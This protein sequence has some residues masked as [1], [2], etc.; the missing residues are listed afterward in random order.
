MNENWLRDA[1]QITTKVVFEP[2]VN[3]KSKILYAASPTIDYNNIYEKIARKYG[4]KIP[5]ILVYNPT[6]KLGYFDGIDTSF[7]MSKNRLATKFNAGVYK[8]DFN[9]EYS[10]NSITDS[11]GYVVDPKTGERS[12]VELDFH[13]DDSQENFSRY[14]EI[15]GDIQHG[16]YPRDFE[17]DIWVGEG[18]ERYS[19]SEKMHSNLFIENTS[20]TTISTDYEVHLHLYEGITYNET[21]KKFDGVNSASLTSTYLNREIYA[22]GHESVIKFTVTQE[23]VDATY[24][25]NPI[26]FTYYSI[27]YGPIPIYDKYTIKDNT[28]VHAIIDF[29]DHIKLQHKFT[30]KITRWSKPYSSVK[31]NYVNTDIVF[32]ASNR[33]ILIEYGLTNSCKNNGDLDYGL[34]YN[35]ANI[36]LYSDDRSYGTVYQYNTNTN[37]MVKFGKVLNVTDLLCDIQSNIKCRFYIKTQLDPYYTYIGKYFSSTVNYNTQSDIVNIDC[38]DITQRLQSIQTTGIG[39]NLRNVSVYYLL[40]ELVSKTNGIKFKFNTDDIK[41]LSLI[42]ISHAIFEASTLWQLLEGCCEIGQIYIVA[43]NYDEDYDVDVILER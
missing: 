3:N 11:M 19:E 23:M 42:K 35:S 10:S 14:I 20:K 21:T 43:N 34:K 13:M 18:E 8:G 25:S 28:C 2:F 5:T 30:L 4:Y 12:S 7:V 1:R 6:K 22:V 16:E 9:I 40:N 33:D 31:L 41:E 24:G 26:A 17:I 15:V 36:K 27:Y 32:E 29:K 38:Y 39:I 37:T